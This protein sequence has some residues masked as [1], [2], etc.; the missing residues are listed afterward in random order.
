MAFV[1][2]SKHV[3][4][5]VVLCCLLPRLS[6]FSLS[7]SRP[8][9]VPLLSPDI[10]CVC[11]Y[12]SGRKGGGMR[13][14]GGGDSGCGRANMLFIIICSCCYFSC[15][16]LLPYI[17]AVC[18]WSFSPFSMLFTC[19][20]VLLLLSLPL[21]LFSL[22][23]IIVVLPCSVVAVVVAVGACVCFQQIHNFVDIKLSHVVEF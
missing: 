1:L 12:E 18:P 20:L 2:V 21:W 9:P 13:W 3:N 7:F 10:E 19:P 4:C 22:L 17:P 15:L 8:P 6:D 16:L 5:C 14:P 23:G 11:D